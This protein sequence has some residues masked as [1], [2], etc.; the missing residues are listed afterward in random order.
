MTG[1]FAKS[2]NI[3]W[4]VALFAVIPAFSQPVASGT[5]TGTVLDPDKMVV[6]QASIELRNPV[7]G[8]NRS[9]M[10]DNV[11]TFLFNNVPQSM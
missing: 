3:T 2:L 11:G 6:P 5:V 9:I 10:T 4:T 8:Y 1:M 7:S